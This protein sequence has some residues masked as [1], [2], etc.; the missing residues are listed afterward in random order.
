MK[1]ILVIN[2]PIHNRGDESAHRCLIKA[3]NEAFP[4]AKIRVL[5]DFGRNKSIENIRVKNA[6]T[7]YVIIYDEPRVSTD[8]NYKDRFIKKIYRD[9]ARYSVRYNHYTLSLLLPINH[10]FIKYVKQADLIINAPGGID[11]GGF[12]NWNDLYRLNI[13]RRY[14]K[15]IAY[16]SRS[17]GPFYK[18]KEVEREFANKCVELLKSVKFLS[19]RDNKSFKIAEENNIPYERSVDTAFLSVPNA[20][21][22]NELYSFVNN[23][24]I[25][26]VPNQLT[27]HYKYK[28]INQ[29]QIDD[30]YVNICDLLLR[31]YPNHHLVMIPQLYDC[32][33]KGDYAYLC[34][35][36][37]KFKKSKIKIIPDNY[38]SD[39]QQ[40]LIR[41][42]SLVV[43]ARYHTI[44]WA[45]NNSRPFVS[46]SYEHKMSGI[47]QELKCSQH[48]FNLERCVLEND[49]TS[50]YLTELDKLLSIAIAHPEAQEM[51]LSKA[52]EGFNTFLNSL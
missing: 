23:P 48:S 43:G 34:Y 15:D 47:L 50:A 16:Y 12:M 42:A 28:K 21:M 49:S 24:Y 35:L 17:I 41:G 5:F 33:K 46:L 14:N 37:E 19:L 1:E 2:Q 44:I 26:M 39:I 51:A 25:V 11:L 52:K 13:C 22:P 29:K 27:W 30:I 8:Y 9:A 36:S 32:G 3:L 10:I 18:N 7:E 31:K 6:N 20:T 4:T 45:I 38:S 40:L